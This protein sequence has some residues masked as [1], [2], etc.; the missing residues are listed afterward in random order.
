MKRFCLKFSNL[1]LSLDL[2]QVK[3]HMLD[4]DVDAEENRINLPI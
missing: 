2:W 4:M 1:K 3:H